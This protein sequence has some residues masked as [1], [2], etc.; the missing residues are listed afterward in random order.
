MFL[1]YEGKDSEYIVKR[2]KR[3]LFRMF[4]NKKK[5]I[6]NVQFRT[7]RL[8][9]FASNKDKIPFLSNSHVVYEYTCPGCSQN[10]IGKTDSTLFKRSGEH[11]WQQKDSAV[12]GHFN[13]CN[14]WH[15]ITEMFG[16]MGKSVD[17]KEMQIN[18]VRQNIKILHRSDNWLK[19]AFLESL[20]IKKHRP[21]LN[22]GVK[23]C[24]ELSLF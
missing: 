16:C 8:S 21:T 4:D 22:T 20:A 6:F 17:Q 1:P 10:Y 12:F 11:G 13:D 19:L 7:T 9:F 15:H 18:N 3:K 14:G 23:A 24:K 2:C 5:V